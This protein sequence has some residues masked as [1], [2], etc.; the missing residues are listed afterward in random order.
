M[1]NSKGFTLIEL[2]ITVA[3]IGALAGIALPSYLESIKKTKRSDAKTE[4]L[5]FAGALERQYLRSGNYTSILDEPDCSSK[6]HPNVAIF[7]ASKEAIDSYAFTVTIDTSDN[8]Y[9][10]YASPQS[11]GSM[12]G[13]GPFLL[14]SSGEK[15][16]AKN[17]VNT[18]A[19]DV[20]TSDW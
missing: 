2:M 1:T 20:Y 13:D 18:V 15:G 4:L 14:T 9:T 6:C 12:D 19:D 8:S 10:I 5:S 17:A 11:T 16:W 3:I 7:T